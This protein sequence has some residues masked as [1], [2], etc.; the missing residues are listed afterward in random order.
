MDASQKPS[1]WTRREFLHTGGLASL[2]LSSAV[3]VLRAASQP[4]QVR[5]T[6]CIFLN[7]LGGP[8][9]LETFDPKPQAPS[10]VRGP[11]QAIATSEPGVYFSEVLPELA[12]RAHRLAVIRS[13]YHEAAPIH[14]T[15]LQLLQTGWLAHT[16]VQHPHFGAVLDWIAGADDSEHSSVILPRELGNLGI[17]KIS[18]GQ[19]SGYLGPVWDPVVDFQADGPLQGRATSAE[20]SRYGNS[21][22]GRSCLSA[23]QWIEKGARAV[24]VNMFSSVF[25]QVTWDAHANGRDLPA[26]LGDYRQQLCPLLDQV[27]SALLDDLEERGLLQETLVVAAGEFGRSP[28]FN[29]CGGRDHWPRCWS[30]VMAGAGISGGAVVGGSDAQGAEPVDRPV[31][32][33]AI[34]ATIFYAMGIHPRLNLL[35][36]EDYSLPLVEADPLLELW[37]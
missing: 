20:R 11:F 17:R 6:R 22:L 30:V 13:V 12:K 25:H 35:P 15:G 32:A 37:G 29:A 23:R 1:G 24:T 2:S 3:P 10:D 5:A 34:P 14:E 9:Q 8:S 21:A 33:S 28:R 4:P 26:T 18:R 36:G 27:L 16:G 31:H 7:L 19:S